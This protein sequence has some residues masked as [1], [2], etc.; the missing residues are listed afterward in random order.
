VPSL[1]DRARALFQSPADRRLAAAA[2]EVWSSAP[3]PS[4]E[5]ALR[6][7]PFDGGPQ[8]PPRTPA[9]NW[10]AD[11][12]PPPPDRFSYQPDYSGYTYQN[13][14]APMAFEGF[15]LERIRN[16]V[17]LHRLGNFFESSALMIAILGFAPALAATKQAI[18]PIISLKR[19]VKG[20][21][22]GLAKLVRGEIEEQLVPQG[23]LLPSPYFPP[24]TWGTMALYHRYMGFSVLQHVDGD[25]DPDTGVRSRYTRIWEPWALQ[26]TRYPRKLVALTTTGPVE[27]KNDGKFTLVADENEP[28][29]SGA[30]VALG[31]EVLAGKITQ[32]ARLS[33]LDFFGKPKL[34]ATLPEKIATHGQAGDAFEAAVNTIYGPDGRG[35]LPY[36]SVLDAVSLSGEGS[37]A[38]QDSLLDLII[39]IFMVMTGSAGTIGSGSA[40]GAGPYQAQKGGAWT[41]RHDLI[42]RP[43]LAMCSGINQGHSAP[44][45]DENYGDAI[46]RAKRAGTW[47]YPTLEVPLVDVDRDER[48][49]SIIAREK[50]RI[51]IVKGLREINA[52]VPQDVADALADDLQV[53]HIKLADRDPTKGTITVEDV[54][55]KL[56]APDEYR[57]DKG[58]GA[59]PNGAGTTQRLSEERLAGKDKTGTAASQGDATV[60]AAPP[61]VPEDAAPEKPAEETAA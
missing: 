16:A 32:E 40:T 33:Y 36:G 58:Y 15:D 19:Y 44:Y 1:F 53:R 22:R 61:T 50:A 54:Q 30:V 34:Y 25:V 23:G 56:F 24:T 47:E 29:M 28:W 18:D 13:F 48:I 17:T 57:A 35:V 26:A 6:A 20:G 14:S 43:A 12:A 38:F 3:K 42:A 4:A 7:S 21:D 39:H 52:E 5:L 49:A 2:A 41:V 59:L 37:K 11:Q 51:E 45:C 60:E 27:V 46:E 10:T 55:E 31:E 9:I 8:G